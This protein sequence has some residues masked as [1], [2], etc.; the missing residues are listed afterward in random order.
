VTTLREEEGIAN[1][2]VFPTQ[3]R[4]TRQAA[5]NNSTA[6]EDLAVSLA[7]GDDQMRHTAEC[8]LEQIDPAWM[9]T[10]A[11]LRARDRLESSLEGSPD[12]VK[13]LIE[14]ALAK[15]PPPNHR[16]S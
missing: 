1:W 5:R 2:L 12:S 11:A 6:L 13:P 8:A 16:R 4:P 3:P 7:D 14:Q 15:L 9:H 10:D